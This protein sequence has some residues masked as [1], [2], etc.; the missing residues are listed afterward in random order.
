M[1][2]TYGT[3]K[4]K[5]S[6]LC[7]LVILFYETAANFSKPITSPKIPA[8]GDNLLPMDTSEFTPLVLCSHF[9]TLQSQNKITIPLTSFAKQLSC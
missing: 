3:H 2:E 9:N 6:F 7:V 8:E 4:V 5:I 1:Q